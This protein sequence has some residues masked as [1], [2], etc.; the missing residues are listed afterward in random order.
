MFLKHFFALFDFFEASNFSV[1]NEISPSENELKVGY[2]T[3]YDSDCI[4]SI[5][6]DDYTRNEQSLIGHHNCTRLRLYETVLHAI[7]N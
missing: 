4:H 2:L 7:S 3:V 6:G 1:E 5:E